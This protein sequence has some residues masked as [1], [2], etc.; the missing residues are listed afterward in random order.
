MAR[1]ANKRDWSGHFEWSQN[2]QKILT[3]TFKLP[4]FRALQVSDWAA[5][6]SSPSGRELQGT[7]S[8]VLLLQSNNSKT[9]NAH[10][11]REVIN[12]AMSGRDSLVLLPTGGGKSLV[13]QLPALAQKGFALVVSPLIALMHDQVSQLKLLGVRAELLYSQSDKGHVKD[14]HDAMVAAASGIKLL[15]VTPEVGEST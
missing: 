2:V 1:A 5:T 10:L 15:Y 4:S 3:D 7:F 14:V 8:P 13:F 12:S 6:I 9:D 11:Q